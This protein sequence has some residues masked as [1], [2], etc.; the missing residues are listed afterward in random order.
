MEKFVCMSIIEVCD[1][2]KIR[3]IWGL[4]TFDLLT[5]KSNQ[6]IGALLY[7]LHPSYIEI[8]PAILKLAW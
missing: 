8:R 3:Q 4:V 2:A 5:P 7:I 1:Q 6:S